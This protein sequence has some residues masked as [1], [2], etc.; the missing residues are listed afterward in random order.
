MSILAHLQAEDVEY[1]ALI[2]DGYDIWK[3]KVLDFYNYG[4]KYTDTSKNDEDLQLILH[5][6]YWKKDKYFREE[7]QTKLD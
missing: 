2:I 5:E 1:V 3:A 6:K 7:I 4:K